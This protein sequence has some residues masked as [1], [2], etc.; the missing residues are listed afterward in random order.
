FAGR[1]DRVR[2]EPPAKDPKTALQEGLQGRRLPLPRYT[3][4]TVGGEAHQQ[5]FRVECRVDELGLAAVGE[6]ASRR[7]AEQQA[8]EGVLGLMAQPK[9]GP[10]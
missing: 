7:A 3:V 2:D 8:A 10:A 4:I 9:A 1:I 5:V 6:G